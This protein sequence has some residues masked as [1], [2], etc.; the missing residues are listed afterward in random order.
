[1]NEEKK[2][3]EVFAGLLKAVES[4]LLVADTFARGVEDLRP[5]TNAPSTIRDVSG[6]AVHVT[7]YLILQLP[8]YTDSCVS[9]LGG[10]LVPLLRYQRNGTWWT[11]NGNVRAID[12]W[13]VRPARG[14]GPFTLQT[15]WKAKILI[16]DA[17]PDL[18]VATVLGWDGHAWLTDRGRARHVEAPLP[19]ERTIDDDWGC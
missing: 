17:P 11:P 18:Q 3:H 2:L 5:C 10:E 15:P 8:D 6:D 1:M 9:V 16:I 7:F 12:I 13:D 4:D 14:Q 19:I